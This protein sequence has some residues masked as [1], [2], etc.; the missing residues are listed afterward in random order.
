MAAAK[1]LTELRGV[2]YQF[3]HTALKLN[4]DSHGL[5]E[6]VGAIPGC[7]KKRQYHVTPTHNANTCHSGGLYLNPHHR[8]K[9]VN[10][11]ATIG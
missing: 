11:E 10:A 8:V 3:N 1:R 7:K 5:S 9:Q 2:N 4:N 6:A